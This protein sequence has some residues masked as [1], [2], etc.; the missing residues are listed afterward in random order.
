MWCVELGAGV[1]VP[2][3]SCTTGTPCQLCNFPLTDWYL[4]GCSNSASGKALL[5]N[6]FVLEGCMRRA[7]EKD[8][9][10]YDKIMYA[11]VREELVP[12]PGE[13][14]RESEATTGAAATGRIE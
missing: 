12:A 7:Y 9:L 14:G 11:L 10:Y 13:G 3:F 6:G 4:C 5:N 2:L 8:G 1:A